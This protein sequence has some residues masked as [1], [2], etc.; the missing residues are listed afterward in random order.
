MKMQ[1]TGNR[2]RGTEAFEQLLRR[3]VPPAGDDPGPE[4]DLWP[5]MQRR[6]NGRDEV[7][8][9][10]GT[11]PWFDWALAAGVAVFTVAFPAAI[12]VLLYYL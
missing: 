6:L 3:A 4:R 8:A 2:D 12:P 1:G 5:A 7:A 11:V 9:K 10:L